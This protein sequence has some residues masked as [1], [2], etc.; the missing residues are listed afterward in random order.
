MLFRSL[1]TPLNENDNYAIAWR[2]R[3]Q[4]YWNNKANVRKLA[5]GSILKVS[6]LVRFTGGDYEYFKKEGSRFIAGRMAGDVFIPL[7]RVR[8]KLNNYKYEVVK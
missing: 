6:E 2:K 1:L 8:F 5:N 4:E 3:V 7:L